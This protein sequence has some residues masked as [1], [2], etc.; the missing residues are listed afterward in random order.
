MK[1]VLCEKHCLPNT[2]VIKD[3]PSPKPAANEVI[4]SIKACS[5]NFPDTLMIQNLYQLKPELPFSPGA[6]VSG[7]IKE[8]GGG[9]K[10]LKVGDH[11][12]SLC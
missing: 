10:H 1:A 9:V 5:A 8:V 11:V 2:L 7:I 3:I 4:I 6:E 12:L